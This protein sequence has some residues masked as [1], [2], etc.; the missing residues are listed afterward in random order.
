MAFLNSLGRREFDSEGDEFIT[1][2]DYFEF[3]DCFNGGGFVSPDDA[4]AI[5]DID[6]DGDVDLDDFQ[7]FLSV[8]EGVIEDCNN[9]GVTD[10][11]EILLG[12]LP[13][14]NNDGI[15]D[16]CSPACPGDLDNSGEID[17]ADLGLLLG[18]WGTSDPAADLDSSGDVDGADLGLLLGGWGLCG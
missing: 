15:S 9:N 14:A 18:A 5:H 10:L 11:Q 8:Y 12:Q 6:Q 17:G 4:C 13:D 16:V 2:F 3:R 1:V 7:S